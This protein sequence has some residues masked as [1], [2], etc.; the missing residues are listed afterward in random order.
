[1]SN[2]ILFNCLKVKNKNRIELYKGFS[3][4]Y[5]HIMF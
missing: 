2:D 3:N 4:E 5:V 1:M